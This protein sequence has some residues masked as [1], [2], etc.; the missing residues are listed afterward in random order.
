[1]SVIVM[2][3]V[4]VLIFAL[5]WYAIGLLPMPAGFPPFVKPVLYIILVL[6]AVWWLWSNFLR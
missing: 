4:A 2:I 1:M 5:L 3:V 6:V